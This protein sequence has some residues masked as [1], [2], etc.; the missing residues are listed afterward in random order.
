MKIAVI[1]NLYPPISRGGAEKVV[2]RV[3][4]ELVRRGHDMVV[5]STMSMAGRATF[6]PEIKETIAETVYRFFPF[7][8]YHTL[9]DHLYPYPVRLLWHLIDLF[10]W[11]SKNRV[12]AI[13]ELEKPD[14]VLTHN[15]K[16]I[17]LRL[18][19]V[20]NEL[21]LPYIHTVHDV[22]LSVPSGLL[23]YG[24]KM[25]LF[26]RVFR[27]PYETAVRWALGKPDLII[28]PSKF[29]ADFYLARG[30][31]KNSSVKVV[32]NPAPDFNPGPRSENFSGTLRLLFAGQLERHKG[33]LDLLEAINLLEIPLELHVA[34]GGS[35]APLFEKMAEQDRR[36]IYHGFVS[37]NNIERLLGIV[38]ATVMPSICYENSPTVIY[39][40]LRSG[41]PVI[42]SDI[43]G[44]GE[45]V[46]H[47]KN[48][49]LVEPANAQALAQTI[50]KFA[51]EVKDFHSRGEAIKASVADY[52]L[53][54]Y[55]DRL[56]G[57]IKD[58]LKK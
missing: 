35:L 20:L 55:V 48:G 10:S 38:D 19:Q 22:Q 28:S 42:A 30:F 8:I 12:A 26:E 41:V 17:G 33:I 27:R 23:M 11:S 43:G 18:P 52:S 16:G 34:G 9:R 13:L 39:E 25:N 6:T 2:Q 40:S 50:R 1:T 53:R 51:T 45:L 37:S 29:L 47:G 14:I 15:L 49:Y 46:Q 4:G 24:K 7:N 32:P 44:V 57:L 5:I 56:E 3:V 21:G 54:F 36:I 58:V 31:F